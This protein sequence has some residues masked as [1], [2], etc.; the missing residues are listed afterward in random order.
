MEIGTKID[1]NKKQYNKETAKVTNKS[2]LKLGQYQKTREEMEKE[3]LKETQRIDEL[4]NKYRERMSQNLYHKKIYVGKSPI[5]DGLD[6]EEDFD[7]LI[8]NEEE[9]QR[10]NIR[11][12][13]PYAPSENSPRSSYLDLMKK[14]NYLKQG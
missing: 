11:I 2:V 12:S 5:M 14:K 9:K 13:S 10:T 6:S 3:K 1:D 8:F 4:A 7:D